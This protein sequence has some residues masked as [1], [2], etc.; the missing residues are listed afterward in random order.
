MAG[1]RAG[2]AGV[3]MVAKESI[4]DGGVNRRGDNDDDDDD[5]NW[6]EEG[7]KAGRALARQWRHKIGSSMGDLAIWSGQGWMEYET[8][9]EAPIAT[10]TGTST[11]SS[12][13]R[14]GRACRR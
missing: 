1:K 12:S 4:N 8:G 10:G 6:E 7:E 9:P 13:A 14:H 2:C 3:V 11:Q 5:S